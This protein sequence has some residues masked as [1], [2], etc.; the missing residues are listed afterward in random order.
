MRITISLTEGVGDGGAIFG[1]DGFGHAGKVDDGVGEGVG[2]ALAF[3]VGV[4]E[5]VGL[6]TGAE[7]VEALGSG[8]E[9]VLGSGLEV[10]VTEGEPVAC[11]LWVAVGAGVLDADSTQITMCEIALSPARPPG[12]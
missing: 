3:C 11:E 6:T 9:V 5:L 8:A 1:C 10:G 7:L 4:G 2:D 12:S